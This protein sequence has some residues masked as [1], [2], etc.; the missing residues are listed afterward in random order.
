MPLNGGM[1]KMH[2]N[3]FTIKVT[4]FPNSL[5]L[6]QPSFQQCMKSSNAHEAGCSGI[7]RAM[8]L[9]QVPDHSLD[10]YIYMHS[11]FGTAA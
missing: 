4:Y 5:S 9:V 1:Y 3:D 2:C 11:R 10:A 7:A 6:H 8:S